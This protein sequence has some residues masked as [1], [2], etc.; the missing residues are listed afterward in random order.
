MKL[1]KKTTAL[2]LALI[3]FISSA[4][5]GIETIA[6]QVSTP[7]VTV[8]QNELIKITVDN[9]TG[10]Y[11][12]RTVEGQPIRKND[13]NVNLMFRGDD[14]ETSFTTFRIDGDDYIFGN[15]YK[16]GISFFS[17]TTKPRIV[18]NPDGTRHIETTWKIKGVAIRQV[19]MLYTD[20]NDKAN[21]GN[22]SIRYEVINNSGADVQ[23]GS[24]ILLDTMVAGNDGPAFQIGTA[25]K[26]PL[27]VER[28]LVHEPDVP[29]EDVNFYKLPPY[30]VM[31]DR[32]DL[33]NPQATNVIA[34]GFNNVA[35]NGFN[36]VDEMIVGHWN[37]L[38]NTK[39]DY[40]VNPNLD[41]TRD[42]NDYGT[43][44]SAV[45]FYWQPKTI[46]QGA[47]T[48]YETVYGL[49]EIIEPDKVF[50]IRYMDPPQQ[51][52]TLGDNSAYSNEGIFDITA[53][54]ENLAM[55]DMEHDSIRS[56]LTLQ[57]GLNFVRLND[58]GEVV[59][60]SSGKAVL[61][62][63]RS[64]E[65]EIRK[66]PTPQ[67]AELGIQPT[68]KP[69]DTITV[70]YKVQAVGRPWP[71]TREYLMTA[72]SPQTRAKLT[73][74][75]DE[76]LMAQYESS[77]SNFILLPAV[78]DAVPTTVF[79]VTPKELYSTDV[80]YITMN[81]TNIEAYNTGNETTQP[82]F[83]LYIREKVTGSRY[84]VPVQESVLMQPT[85]DGF[86]GD[87]RI[88]YRG[89]EIVDNEG[90]K[91]GETNG[92]ELPLGEYQMELDYKGTLGDDEETA[93]L[94]DVITA[95][96]FM[97]TD[98]DESRMRE[99]GILA[100]YKQAIDV[101]SINSLSSHDQDLLDELNSMFPNNPFSS[102]S[103]LS[104]DLVSYKALRSAFGTASKAVDPEFDLSKFLDDKVY[105]KVP[106]YQYKMFSSEKE[107]EDFFSDDDY[108]RERLV[109]IRGM[110]KEVGTGDTKQV[111]VDTKTEPAIINESVAYRGKDLVF[112]RGQLEMFG[113]KSDSAFVRSLFVKGDGTL[114]VAS[115]G[116]IFHKGEWTLDFYNGF[117][118]SLGQGLTVGKD[119]KADNKGNEEDDT[120]NGS[121]RWA[122][123]ALG[124]RLNPMRQ[125]MIENVYF[126][127][128]SL[129]AP[130][131]FA[132][133]GFGFSFND[134]ILREGGIS[135]GGSIKLKIIEGEVNNV[136]FNDEGFV[137]VDAALKF[138]LGSD[139]G[140]INAKGKKEKGDSASGE[141]KVVHYVQPVPGVA[142]TYGI[143]FEAVLK[144]VVDIGVELA[145]KK[146][147]DGRILPDVIGFKT[148]LGNPGVLVTGA[149]Y[150]TG[151]R[152]AIRELADT[153]A[154]GSDK[155]PFPLVVQAGV[156]MRFG[157]APAYFFGD[158]DLTVKRT[159]L[160]IEGKLD[161]STNPSPD[162]DDLMEMVTK[163]LLEAQWVTPWF[164]RVETEVNIGGW[165]IIIGRA[166]IF[167][168][169]NLEKNRTDFEG[170]IGAKL[171]IPSNVPIVGG[172]PLAS[173]FF[174]VNN[175]KIWGS[176]GIL[177][178]S[179]GITYYWGGGIEFG[180]SGEQLPD[181]LMH[182]VVEDPERGP[183]LMV[184]GQGMETLATSWLNSEQETHEITY[185]QVAEGVQ[186][187]ENGSASIGI[188]GINVK[189]N[190][191]VHEIAMNDVSGNAIIEVAYDGSARPELKLRDASGANHPIVYDN[192]NT[193]K[194]ANAYTQIIPAGK[195]LDGVDSR[196]V[197]IVL[198]DDKLASG[199]NW[200]LTSDRAVDTRLLNVPTVPELMNVEL[201]KNTSNPNLFTASWSVANA[202]PGDTIN[203]YLTDE[204][205]APV[206]D[207]GQAANPKALPDASDPGLL[208]AKNLPVVKNGGKTGKT[209]SGSEVI[210]VTSVS[211][212]GDR[213]DI[214]GL[215]QQGNYYLRAE[216][217]SA[218]AYGTKTSTER[219]ELIDPLAPEAVSDV[220]VKP[221]GNGLFALS[222]K[223]K[224]KKSGHSAFEHSYMIEARQEKGGALVPYAA[225]GDILFTEEELAP[226]YNSQ[227]GQY[228]NILIGGWSATSTSDEV[229]LQS[230]DGDTALRSSYVYTGLEV[231]KEYV[232]GVSS[233]TKPTKEA[234]KNENYH[235]ANRTDAAKRLL[236][237]PAKPKLSMSGQHNADF[238]E[239]LTKQTTQ[240]I[241]LTSDQ[242]D[243]EVEAFYDDK[244]VGKVSLTNAG[245]GSAGAISFDQFDTD[246]P[247]A[248]E[249][250][251]RNKT[252]RD[253]AVTML[254]LTVDTIAPKL[255]IDQPLTGE[256]TSGGE[257]RIVGS[258]S[259]DAVLTV[260]GTVVELAENGAFDS[261]VPI[262]GNDPVVDLTFVARDAA[263]NE[264]RA[265][266]GITN[267]SFRVP[268]AL[269][270]EELTPMKPGEARTLQAKLRYRNGNQ[271]GKPVYVEETI[272]S[273][274][275]ANL[276]YQ[277]TRG[278]S[279]KLD[280]NGKVTAQALG[281][282]LIEAEYRISEDVTLE[283][284]VAA[285]VVAPEQTA[286]RSITASTAV[287]SG[288][289]SMTQVVVQSA[290]EMTGQQ[291]VYKVFAKGTNAAA[292]TFK[293]KIE[294]WKFLPQDGRIAAAEGDRIIVAARTS[295][296]KETTAVSGIL[297]ARIYTDPVLPGPGGP[298]GPV[299]PVG[300]GGPGPGAPGPGA[301][302]TTPPAE[303]TPQTPEQPTGPIEVNVGD[304]KVT[305]QWNGTTAVLHVTDEMVN[306]LTADGLIIKAQQSNNN[307]NY[308]LKID[309]A[310]V[311][312]TTDAGSK[313]VIDLPLAKLE[314]DHTRLAAV[315]GDLEL[316]IRPA[317]ATERATDR[318][319]ARGLGAAALGAGDGVIISSNLP[320]A[321]WSS[322]IL[323]SISVPEGIRSSD[324]TAVVLR[325]PDG[326]S[327][328]TVPWKLETEGAHVSVQ[329]TG[330][331]QLFFVR[332]AGEFQDVQPG[333]WAGE[334]IRDAA[335]KLFVLG[336]GDSRF[337]PN[338]KITR[339]E[340]PTILLRV[341]GWM[342]KDASSDFTD[343]QQS[344]WFNRSV[345]VASQMGIVNGMADG[346]Y[347]PQS[348]L[349]RVEAM[350]MVGRLLSAMNIGAEITE[351]QIED[352]LAGFEDEAAIPEWA[353]RPVAL[354]V[355]SGIITGDNNR[356]KPAEVLTR[357]QAAAI[358]IRLDRLIT[359]Y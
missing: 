350:A 113:R 181:G 246:G 72:S 237:V 158:V 52:A 51:L 157:I 60:D 288:N 280:K 165:D 77:Q 308:T 143:K 300:P 190:G 39:W 50:S 185:R 184:I 249:L 328:T 349:T 62:S 230:L 293:Q 348:S 226:F 269:V 207:P 327:W 46:A 219:F 80:K 31:R 314:L 205:V 119:E 208:I 30:W 234:D 285:S 15:P 163:A 244:S 182:L 100:V 247:Y 170:F 354:S 169:Q 122:V 279:I 217:K 83:D 90:R 268:T 235:F 7:D 40:E 224:A 214:R 166:G 69:G 351:A 97:V 12:I 105:E 297:T 257:I 107:L 98:N 273:S 86:S 155:D 307:K 343:V 148:S 131:S 229:N 316:T 228:E 264:N 342:N 358:A 192:T 193:V 204:P 27:L 65:L 11:G 321:S 253:M 225:F 292:P 140:L 88:T 329:L 38:A 304:Q 326:S 162:D 116:F 176:V 16:F 320:T 81:L 317:S 337:D 179:I 147:K 175:D 9:S 20:M 10:R 294:D 168:G 324:I 199:G 352:I 110:V 87:M 85:D 254:Y 133:G 335:A 266:V 290:G 73:D 96:T 331:G 151:V 93:D 117:K 271:N 34:Y 109:V 334:S 95:Q 114:S 355:Q 341:A 203:L 251:A 142:N 333:F 194:G 195:A 211:L 48:S 346:S 141:L 267:D 298:G 201:T 318:E 295:L 149:T 47:A 43:A 312:K 92:P 79:G 129:F 216:L 123:G 66:E 45:A 128:Q 4:A 311:K 171:Q 232:I 125:V 8:L 138:E 262:K 332:S 152:G 55:F 120:L 275:L 259:T 248:I 61:E 118:K 212:L 78:G 94:F 210:D 156:S 89:G 357:A 67:E 177:F 5:V 188:G 310:A 53:E 21:I 344:H 206:L 160:K 322:P 221:A 183:T 161:F 18:N 132:I 289:K 121:L 265:T 270:I 260:G 287:V 68:F 240:T 136:V 286:I 250:V 82:N 186:I 347:M 301:P 238:L 339:A 59:R 139:I 325:S 164:V 276:S 102:V 44:D 345:S 17:E 41:Y 258:T 302:G 104:S 309:R 291:L 236:P 33:N 305:A 313:L 64:K 198:P 36:I 256:R 303:E 261:M 223:P 124:D 13:Q 3:L 252:T 63:F 231:G 323:A 115:S 202:K 278:D 1:V 197:Y 241:Q 153:I 150:L 200:T 180:T 220:V 137:G 167:V 22:V 315:T 222:F 70:S 359:D 173:V 277:V 74:T 296:N 135:F 112:V 281:A 130:P 239:V 159:G 191:R 101:S 209:T 146:V 245:S 274:K 336:K 106:F 6:A 37:G 243:V 76:G 71:V 19:L 111:I 196:K 189:N 134:F 340:Y 172:M 49:G 99:A 84:K 58:R 255:F 353:R 215:L 35:E 242:K 24:R 14:P 263:G 42:T 126:N 28:K 32:L 299:G 213:E 227:T 187:I 2:L 23:I 178:I 284:M 218:S 174:G 57:G 330:E 26:A 319:I 29:E 54:I 338:S 306:N 154:G 283:T 103:G 145:F 56:E 91:I 25:Y 127:R 356:V 282:S 108:D 75:E 144:E 272:P 233:V